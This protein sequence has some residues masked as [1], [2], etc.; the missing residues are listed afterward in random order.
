MASETVVSYCSIMYITLLFQLYF[1]DTEASEAC[2]RFLDVMMM[3]MMMMMRKCNFD[4][5]FWSP[6]VL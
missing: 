2:V 3:M 1:S 6:M 5:N 4:T